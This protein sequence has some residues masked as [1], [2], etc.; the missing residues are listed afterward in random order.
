MT[1][2]IMN[3]VDLIVVE[4][5]LEAVLINEE[6]SISRVACEGYLCL[7][8]GSPERRRVSPRARVGIDVPWISDSDQISNYPA[9][10]VLDLMGAHHNVGVTGS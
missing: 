1:P 4:S 10:S 3:M 2:V 5:G 9:S 8:C 6:R 7:V